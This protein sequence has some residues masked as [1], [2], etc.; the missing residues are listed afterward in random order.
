MKM[1]FNSTSTPARSLVPSVVAAS[2]VIAWTALPRAASANERHFTF[3][4]ETATLPKG[5]KEIE[6][7]TTPRIGR[8]DFYS[9]FDNRAEFEVG[10]TDRLMTA[11]YLNFTSITAKSATGLESEFEFAGVSSEWKYKIMDPVADAVGFAVYGEVTGAPSELEL[12][13]KLLFDKQVGNL[14][15]AA[16][17]VGEYELEF[18]GEMNGTE[19]EIETEKEIVV[20]VDLGASWIVTPGVGIGL[21]LRNHN[22]VH[23]GDFE[24]SALFA[25]PTFWYATDSWWLALSVLPQLP[26]LKAGEANDTLVLDEHE[27]VMARLLFSIHI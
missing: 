6:I 12:E 10:V 2:I 27:K 19:V 8:D 23:D 5:A 21:E 7:W 24:H 9:R 22:E 1:T 11:L 4:Y 14:L 15:L 17:L 16:N 25:G 13:A 18:E 26:A 3:T 20:E